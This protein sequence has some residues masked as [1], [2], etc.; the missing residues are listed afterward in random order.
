M[1]T[2]TDI[3]L[4]IV[5]KEIDKI[6]CQFA[7]KCKRMLLETV[8]I[9]DITVLS[10]SEERQFQFINTARAIRLGTIRE[11]HLDDD[12]LALGTALPEMDKP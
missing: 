3:D 2:E 7:I 1:S 5:H 10:E 9:A 12:L 8:S 11:D 4:L 6:S